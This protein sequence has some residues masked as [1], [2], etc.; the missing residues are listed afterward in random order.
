MRG[1]GSCT[2]P[3]KGNRVEEMPLRIGTHW[4]A[5][6]GVIIANRADEPVMHVWFLYWVLSMFHA[7]IASL[8]PPGWYMLANTGASACRSHRSHSMNQCAHARPESVS[9][10]MGGWP[11]CA[12]CP[13]GGCLRNM[14]MASADHCRRVH[15]WTTTVLLAYWCVRSIVVAQIPCGDEPCLTHLCHGYR[16]MAA[17]VAK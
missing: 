16:L 9:R 2:V 13:I 15:P 6:V 11:H 10:T 1:R 8:K 14:L 4:L 12:H 5:T 17:T 7:S 3:R